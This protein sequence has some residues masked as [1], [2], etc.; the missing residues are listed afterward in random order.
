M[1]ALRSII[2]QRRVHAPGAERDHLALAR[3]LL[4][5]RGLRGDARGLAEQTEE[6]G[7]VLR[8]LHV[9]ALD[10]EH[11]LIGGEQRALVHGA[12]VDRHAVEQRRHLL[13]AGEHAPLP[14]FGEALEVDLGLHALAIA[15]VGQD[16]HRA[17]EVDV[18]HLAALDLGV[19]CGVKRAL[20]GRHRIARP[21]GGAGWP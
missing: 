9:G 19:G 10:D 4:A 17:S 21:P 6:G 18:G 15:P 1:K 5:A 14:V 20:R 11:R 3:R 12:H 16:L 7:L 13:D 2:G 8:P